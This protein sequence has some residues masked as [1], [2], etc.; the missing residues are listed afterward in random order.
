MRRTGSS[1]R[2]RRVRL[3]NRGKDMLLR[4]LG[5]SAG[6]LYPGVWCRCGTC[7]KA[8]TGG[9]KDRRQSAALYIEPANAS[10]PGVLIDMPSE[11]V[12]QAYRHKV[13]LPALQYLLVT[14]SHG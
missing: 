11:I 9:Q 4:F 1:K 10:V 7:H 2:R 6:E 12:Q 3:L 13:D 14:H 5:T 8:R